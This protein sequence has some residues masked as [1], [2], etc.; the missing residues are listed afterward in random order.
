MSCFSNRWV[1]LRVEFIGTVV[2]TLASAFA[3]IEKSNVAQGFA[4]LSI[5]YALQLTGILNWLVRQAT[6]AE[7]QMVSVERV[8]SYTKLATEAAPIVPENRPPEDWPAR[9]I[10]E[11]KDVQLRYREGLDLVLRGV[12][13]SVKSKEKIGVVG[14]TGAGK[15]SL[16]LALFR[17]VEL[18][19]GKILIDG[20]D[21]AKI[22][23][24]DLR[25][26]LSIIPQDP[27]L[28]TG[29]IRSNL[30][31]FGRYSDH[32]IWQ[33]LADCHLKA[34]VEALPNKLE[35]PVSEFGEN[36]SVGQRQLM[37]LGRAILCRAK[38][39]I[40]DEATAAVDFET[41]S[42]IQKTIRDQF[43]DV[44][45]LTIAHRINTILDYDRILVLDRGKVAEYES[46]QILASD[47]K[48]VFYSLLNKSGRKSEVDE[49]ASPTPDRFGIA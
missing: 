3:V 11:F 27:T 21:I 29:T 12:S 30:D 46:P 5:S 20:I 43:K 32:D 37:C 44:T 36:F 4:G 31:P 34:S 6:E 26:K 19:G 8:L 22:G 40:M 41:D 45:V 48:S 1:G 13:F 49:I 7:T 10:I 9:G 47:P 16:M 39:L 28:F 2:V 15:S 24:D 33:A 42:L 38:I 18:A 25:S 14:R 35:S 23:L 17:L